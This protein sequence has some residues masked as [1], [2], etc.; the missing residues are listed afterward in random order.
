MAETSFPV[1]EQPL[2][3]IQWKSVARGFGTGVLDEG[4]NPYNLTNLNNA[5]NTAV[6]AVDTKTGYNHAVVS[7]FYHKMDSP[8][9]ITIP[10]VNRATTYH[11]VLRYDP[12]DKAMPVRLAVVTSLDRS[13]GKEYL[14]LWTV[15]RSA[16]QLLSDATI[17]KQRPIIAP[18]IVVDNQQSLPDAATQLWGT[19][20]YA[21]Q[22]SEEFRATYDGRWERISPYRADFNQPPGW[23]INSTTYGIQVTPTTRGLHCHATLTPIRR[24]AGYTI[25]NTFSPL[26]VV[27][28]AGYRPPERCFSLASKGDLVVEAMLD[29]TGTLFLR[30]RGPSFTYAQDDS[31]SMSFSWFVPKTY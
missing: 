26:G 9:T 29:T 8:L 17:K 19:R 6:I 5:S 30:G 11:V 7:G 18:T 3:D 25:G 24:S 22:T 2:S 16:N 21:Q 14:V 31:C 28:P 13:A 4:G 1:L 12:M 10:A 27:I 20:A 15:A 23:Q